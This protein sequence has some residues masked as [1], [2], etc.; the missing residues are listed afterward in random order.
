MRRVVIT[1]STI[2]SIIYAQNYIS[3]KKCKECHPDI[4]EEYMKSWHSKGYFNDELHKRVADKVPVY[5]C[6]KCH[7][8]ADR[9]RVS[10]ENGRTS[11]SE[12]LAEDRDAISCFYCHQIAFVKEAHSSNNIILA[13]QAKGYK[14]TLFGSLE[15]P[16]SSDK[17]SMI[18]SPIY[19]RYACIGCHSHK[20][21][22]NGVLIFQATKSGEGSKDCIRCHMPYESGSVEKLNRRN[23][24]K[25]RS[26]YFRGIHDEKMRAKSVDINISYSNNTLDINLTNKMGHPLIIQAAREKFLKTTIYR[27]DKIIW[28]SFKHSPEEDREALFRS[29]FLMK[30]GSE[31]DIPYFANKRGYYNNLDAYKSKILHY[32][33]PTL[34]KGDRIVSEMFVIL[35]KPSCVKATHLDKKWQKPILMKRVEIRVK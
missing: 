13:K 21:N 15:N 28:S 26:H 12:R 34:Y 10:L 14:P 1:L 23:R 33:T 19:E 9:N 29:D 22:K 7:M 16:D 18:H 27:G 25:R 11:P 35:A 5:D 17:H 32:K 4:Y 30:D 6:A 8:P 3:N 31:A 20:R 24:T 2:V